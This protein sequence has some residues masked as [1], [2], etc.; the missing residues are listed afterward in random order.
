MKK[1][2]IADATFIVDD[3]LN[4]HIHQDGRDPIKIDAWELQEISKNY[5]GANRIYKPMGLLF[6]T[7]VK[8]NKY[9]NWTLI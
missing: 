7:D 9:S 8:N 3:S 4:L 5:Q 1:T 2:R 6:W